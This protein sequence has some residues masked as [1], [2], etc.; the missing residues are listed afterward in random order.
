[1]NYKDYIAV[2]EDFPIKG[3]SFKDVTPLLQDKDA[4]NA[5]IDELSKKA[6]D[7]GANLVVAP[8]SRG[9]L[10][11][12]PMAYKMNCGFVPIRKPGK[13]PREN[14][15][16]EYELEYGTN[17]LCVHT[18]AIKPG[19]K[20]VIVDD[21]LATGGTVNATAKMVEKLGGT[22]VGALFVIELTELN[23]RKLLDGIKVEALTIYPY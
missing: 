9:F 19:D 20:V 1:M 21:L 22:V 17:K 23:G 7:M 12:C 3:I 2:I 10:F 13:L 6:L 15:S 14:I 4:Y 5:C 8:E 11:G 18:D 16:Q